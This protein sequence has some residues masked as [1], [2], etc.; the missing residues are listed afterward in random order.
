MRVSKPILLLGPLH[1]SCVWELIS[2]EYVWYVLTAIKKFS[3]F[4]FHVCVHY[5]ALTQPLQL[6]VKWGSL[7]LS[8]HLVS[9]A[10]WC[11]RLSGFYHW[12]PW[13][14]QQA[15]LG[16]TYPHSF[17]CTVVKARR[18]NTALIFKLIKHVWF[19]RTHTLYFSIIVRNLH[20]LHS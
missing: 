9:L 5:L 19:E 16:S 17:C 8:W 6:R 12:K 14:Q 20:W 1:Y 11:W 13:Q 4:P 7:S 15:G 3:T 10:A 2:F 18:L